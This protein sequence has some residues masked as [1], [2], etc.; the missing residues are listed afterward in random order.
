VEEHLN[1]SEARA[2]EPALGEDIKVMA[3]RDG[4]AIALTIA[5]AMIDQSL[6][7]LRDYAKAKQTVA[8][9]ALRVAQQI[10]SQ[11][12]SVDVNAADDLSTGRVY[13]TVTGTS[14]E[15]GDDGQAGR[16]NRANGLITPGRPMTIESVAGKNPVTHVGKLYNLVASLTA[17][18]LVT[19]LTGVRGAECRFVSRIGQPIDEPQLLEVRL[20][21]VD[22]KGDAELRGEV[23]RIVREEL[24]HLPQL[25]DE[26]LRGDLRLNR[27]PMR[28]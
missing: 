14:A 15:A 16:G 8:E 11:P 5:C 9:L 24:G 7:G 12:V 27:W 17:E 4:D 13:L 23:E 2:A 10:T 19:S 6:Q 26:L 22:P 18:R 1:S 20:A 21:G 28:A 25:A 3:I